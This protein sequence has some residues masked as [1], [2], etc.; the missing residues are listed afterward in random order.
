MIVFVFFAFTFTP[1]KTVVP[2][3]A[4]PN[5][6]RSSDANEDESVNGNGNRNGNGCGDLSVNGHEPG[7]ERTWDSRTGFP[8]EAGGARAAEAAALLAP[9][10]VQPGLVLCHPEAEA[11]WRERKRRR[12]GLRWLFPKCLGLFSGSAS[13]RLHGCF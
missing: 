11:G 12:D 3:R 13:T 8:R 7:R 1:S 6:S 2:Q 10:F 5:Y 9:E 4:P